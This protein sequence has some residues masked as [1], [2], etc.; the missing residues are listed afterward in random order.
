MKRTFLSLLVFMTLSNAK[1]KTIVFFNGGPGM[2][3]E[4]ERHMLAPYLHD[5]GIES[6]FWDEPSELRSGYHG[7]PEEAFQE[8][9]RSAEKFI[10]NICSEKEA[11]CELTLVAHSYSVQYIVRIAEKNK[12]RIRE[13]VLLSP[14]LNVK[15]AD[16][17]ILNLAVRGLKEE[18]LG[19]AS[20]E[21]ETLIPE[22]DEAFDQKKAK[23]YLIG[24]QYKGLF[25]NYWTN[26]NLMGEYFSHMQGQYGFDLKGLFEVRSS[27]PLLKNDVS[28]KISIP[29]RAYFGDLDPVSVPDE[30]IPYLKNYFLN[31]ETSVIKGMKHYPH[32][33]NMQEIK[34]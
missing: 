20:K 10:Q 14:G 32:I 18:G 9:T 13:I 5:L 3:S 28:E 8:A 19:E 31:L 33:E 12:D 30:Q 27:M 17:N 7:K 24:A 16:K 34:F 23:A 11:P 15:A 25:L 6:H 22:L 21:L 1:A 4:P 26:F 29:T 2:N